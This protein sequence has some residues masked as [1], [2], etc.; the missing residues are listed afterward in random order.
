MALTKQSFAAQTLPTVWIHYSLS[1]QSTLHSGGK[2]SVIQPWGSPIFFLVAVEKDGN[3]KH[4]KNSKVLAPVARDDIIA[5]A[6][7]FNKEPHWNHQSGQSSFTGLGPI[8]HSSVCHQALQS[9]REQPPHNLLLNG[10][11][12][13]ASI[14]SRVPTLLYTL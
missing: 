14:T 12:T 6:Q 1:F 11:W 5:S 8:Q 13:L 2:R 10:T 9:H 3:V 4:S 7:P